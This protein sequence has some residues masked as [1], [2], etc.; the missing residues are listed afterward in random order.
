[1]NTNQE[2][3]YIINSLTR[4]VGNISGYYPAM[5]I[6]Q[7]ISLICSLSKRLTGSNKSGVIKSNTNSELDNAIY[8]MSLI[9][10]S[11]GS[12]KS[13]SVSPKIH[14]AYKLAQRLSFVTTSTSTT[15]TTT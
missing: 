8:N 5:N 3:D 10:G 14:F 4:L 12:S 13:L 6:T 9:A 11:I 1:M 2:L 15:T 7:K